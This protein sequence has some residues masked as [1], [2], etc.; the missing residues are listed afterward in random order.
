ML[1]STSPREAPF[2][3]PPSSPWNLP[4]FTAESTLSSPCSRSDPPLSRQGAALACLDS[5]PPHDLVLW[6]DSS[7]PFPFGKDGSSVLVNYSLCGTDT[8]FSFSAGPACSSFFCL[9]L[10]HSASSLLVSTAP[11]SLPFFFSSPI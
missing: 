2:A 5:L 10:R 7:V 4:S 3:S 6:T 9:S 11:T 1:L 8:T